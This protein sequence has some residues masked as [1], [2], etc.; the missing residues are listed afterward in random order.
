M[1][2]KKKKDKKTYNSRQIQHKTLK[3]EQHEPY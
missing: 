2:D 1:H 3:I